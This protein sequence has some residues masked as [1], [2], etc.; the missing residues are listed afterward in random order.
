[1][2]DIDLSIFL[3]IAYVINIIIIIKIIAIYVCTFVD[4]SFISYVIRKDSA[5][6][7]SHSQTWR[8]L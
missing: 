7:L 5:T 6:C 4:N 2:L 1:M 8:T 3:Y